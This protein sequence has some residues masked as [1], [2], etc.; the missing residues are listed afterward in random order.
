VIG[1]P[2]PE[3]TLEV[4]LLVIVLVLLVT[5]AASLIKKQKPHFPM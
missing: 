1:I 4:S 3:I 5:T 2:I